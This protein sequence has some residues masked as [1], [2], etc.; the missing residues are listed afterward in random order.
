MRNVQPKAVR[1]VWVAP[2]LSRLAANL[3]ESG[4]TGLSDNPGK[5]QS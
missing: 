1:Q 4:G 5:G 2:K 3:A